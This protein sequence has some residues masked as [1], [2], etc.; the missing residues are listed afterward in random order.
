MMQKEGVIG[1][2]EYDILPEKRSLEKLM[3]AVYL[4]KDVVV[5]MDE[6][7]LIITFGG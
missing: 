3:V 7:E 2:R 1:M 4:L 6:S 5:A